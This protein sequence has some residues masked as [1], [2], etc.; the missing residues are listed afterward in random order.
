MKT[1][2]TARKY[3][4]WLIWPG[5]AL[6]TAGLVVGVVDAW[7]VL[8]IVLLA[9]GGV[10]TLVSLLLGGF[11]YRSFWQSRST[12]A[13]TNAVLATLSV[14]LILGVANFLAVQYAPSIDLT[15]GRLFTLAPESQAVVKN[16]E[17]PV[18]VVLFD[19]SLNPNDKQLLDSYRKFNDN[20]TYEH[21]NPFQDPAMAREF[22]VSGEGREVHLAVGDDQIFVQTLGAQGLNEQD[23]TNKLAQLGRERN[24]VVYFLQGHQ[25]FVIDGSTSGYAQAATALEADNFTVEPL[26]LDQTGTIPA[27][28][29]AVIVAGPKQAFFEPEIDAL[30][31]YLDQGGSA[32][33][34]LDPQTEP[35]LDP[36]LKDWGIALDERLIID[37]SNTGQIVGLGPAAP[38][39]TTYGTHPITEAFNNGRSFYPLA[40]PILVAPVDGVDATPLLLSNTQSYAE[41]VSETGE[42]NVDT[43]KP[44]EGPFNIGVALTKEIDA[45]PQENAGQEPSENSSSEQQENQSEEK[46]A[47]ENNTTEV[48]PSEQSTDVEAVDAAAEPNQEA[49]LVVIGN[50]TFATDGLF[51]QQLN[52]DVFL[53]TVT[54]LSNLDDSILSIRPKEI[55]NRR[56]TMTV[57]RQIMII[58]LALLVFPLIGLVGAGVTWF[59][60]R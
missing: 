1:L 59:R 9:V 15:E 12:Q 60:R 44:P 28:A 13:G 11:G 10:F 36:L 3:L 35:E 50:A 25:E 22:N 27:D 24:A 21:I 40:R 4:R 32:L 51:D 5:L 39:V 42:L 8:P 29:N 16:L 6:M 52:G 46:T 20:L 57:S 37:A 19:S 14:L 33:L 43:Q 23:L 56:I 58:V 48:D 18:N 47:E 41:S 49:R 54:W 2:S 45:S 53:N 55:T 34:L 7:N 17:Q 31:A 38:L 26:Q 30:K